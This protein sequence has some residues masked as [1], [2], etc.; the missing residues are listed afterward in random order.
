[1]NLSVCIPVYGVEKYIARC[2]RSLFEQTMKEGIE[3]IFVNDCTQDNSMAVL[4]QVLAEYPE[5]KDQVKIIHHE[6]NKGLVSARKTGI[7][8]AVGDYIIHCDSDDW[9]EPE[10]YED[11]YRAAIQQD[12]DLVYCAFVPDDGNGPI[13]DFPVQVYQNMKDLLLDPNL[14]V[15]LPTKLFRREHVI[16]EDIDV[17]DDLCYGEDLLRV[18]QTLLKCKRVACCPRAYYHYFRGND[19]SYTLSFNRKSLDQWLNA[20]HNLNTRFP[21]QLHL[22]KWKGDA[23]YQAIVRHLVTT[24][25]YK[26]IV[27]KDFFK[28]LNARALHPVKK[29]IIL[30]ANISYPFASFIFAAVLRLWKRNN[31]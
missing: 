26:A 31:R 21:G 29:G 20:I 19:S 3:F 15:A 23:L 6:K 13:K 11:M 30:V 8:H 27:G 1:M 28:M 4:E 25:E 2:A 24:E 10:I 7:A 18:T 14:Y 17:P 5:R 16:A 22:E 9:V 12:A